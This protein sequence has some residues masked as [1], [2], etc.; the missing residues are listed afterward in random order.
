M[1]LDIANFISDSGKTL[2]GGEYKN[3]S[4]YIP[5]N[6]GVHAELTSLELSADWLVD[7]SDQ[8]IRHIRVGNLCICSIPNSHWV[9][10]IDEAERNVFLHT[11]FKE[12]I[13]L[14]ERNTFRIEI[15]N[16]LKTVWIGNVCSFADVLKNTCLIIFKKLIQ[17][18][19]PITPAFYKMF[20]SYL[21]IFIWMNK[22]N[23][24]FKN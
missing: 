15:D 5:S 7:I 10:R 17:N 13:W 3:S 20:I 12:W 22:F 4:I 6:H 16:E 11:G 21:F 14:I 18:L 9:T 1:G 24:I 8:Y 19:L 23:V 2:Y